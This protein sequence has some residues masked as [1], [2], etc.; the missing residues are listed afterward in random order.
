MPIQSQARPEW[1]SQECRETGRDSFGMWATDF[2]AI[3]KRLLH[4]LLQFSQLF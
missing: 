4:F 2:E 1:H 3:E